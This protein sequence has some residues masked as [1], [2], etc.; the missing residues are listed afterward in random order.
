MLKSM[1]DHI[2]PEDSALRLTAFLSAAFLAATLPGIGNDGLAAQSPELVFGLGHEFDA[3]AR[4]TESPNFTLELHGRPSWEIAAARIGWTVGARADTRGD[5]WVGVG[6]SGQADISERWFAEASFM[7]GLY[8]KGSNG[9][10]LGSGVAFRTLGGIAYRLTPETS[11]GVAIDHKSNAGLGSSNPGINTISLR[12]R[13][14][15]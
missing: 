14:Q 8:R 4:S 1:A 2:Q 10:R 12:L 15:F 9:T 7:P 6:L 3:G 13:Q 5:I 11:L